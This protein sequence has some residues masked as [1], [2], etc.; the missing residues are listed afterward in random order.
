MIR[1]LRMKFVLMNMVFVTLLLSAVFAVVIQTTR[2]SL[3]RD[4]MQAME[5]AAIKL[6][7]PGHPGR[8]E[9]TIPCFTLRLGPHGELIAEGDGYYDLSDEVWLAEL[10]QEALKQ[11]AEDG[12]LPDYNLRF[13]RTGPPERPTLSFADMSAEE[14]TRASLIRTCLLAG[15]AAFLGFLAISVLLSRWAVRPVERAW[16]QQR[17]FVADASHEL[18]TPLTVILT[19]AELLRGD[20]MAGDADR[21]AGNILSTARRMHSLVESLLELARVEAAP[22]E[23]AM[24]D[25]DLSELVREALLPFEPAFFEQGLTL[26]SEIEDGVRV[27]GVESQLRQVPEIL[28][29]NARKYAAPGGAVTA[30]LRRSGRACVFSVFNQGEPLTD[31]ERED[32]FKRFYRSDPARSREGG[33]GLGLAIARS[34]VTHHGGK[35][36]A[37]SGEGGNTFLV[38]LPLDGKRAISPFTDHGGLWH[39]NILK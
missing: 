37:E 29:D 30:A 21:F 16:E 22:A 14:R 5:Q 35:I 33:Y 11:G 6:L 31:Q 28:L 26:E 8:R 3:A 38:R 17:Q 25:V 1:R 24:E 7:G 15:S 20:G 27:R 10:L 18:K 12:V 36:W 34:I 23:A 2:T 4:T 19:N 32:V 39:N 9:R 13:Y